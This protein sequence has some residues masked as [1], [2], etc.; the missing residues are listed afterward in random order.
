MQKPVEGFDGSWNDQQK[1]LDELLE[2][3]HNLPEGEIIDGVISFQ[4]ADGY[5]MYRVVSMKPLKVQHIPFGDSYRV[6][7]MTIRGMRLKD[8]K[9]ILAR[10]RALYQLFAKDSAFHD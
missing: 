1:K 4:V 6:D 9:D 8:V 5:A 7:N 2:K 10:E 3:S